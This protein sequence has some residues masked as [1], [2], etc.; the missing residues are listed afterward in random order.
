MPRPS[1]NAYLKKQGYDI[2]A[3]RDSEMPKDGNK[4]T[5]R[6]AGK[7]DASLI[8]ERL[9]QSMQKEAADKED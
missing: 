2:P 6:E 4:R 3:W 9:K 8:M 1:P 5:M 7:Q